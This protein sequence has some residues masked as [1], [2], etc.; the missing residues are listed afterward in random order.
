M[1][2]TYWIWHLRGRKCYMEG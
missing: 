2:S 1:R